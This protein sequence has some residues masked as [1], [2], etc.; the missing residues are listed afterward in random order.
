MSTPHDSVRLCFIGMSNCGKSTR[1]NQLAQNHQFEV[2]HVDER[3]EAALKPEL[4]S[5]GFSGIE[6]MSSWMGQ[7]FD[8]RFAGN[9]KRYLELEEQITLSADFEG[10]A[11]AVLDCTG[12]V[13]NINAPEKLRDR[14][15]VVHFEATEEIV[16]AMVE[17]YFQC[18]KPVAWGHTFSQRVGESGEEALRRCYPEMLKIRL[19]KYRSLAHFSIPATVSLDPNFSSERFLDLILANRDARK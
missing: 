1:A 19:E 5:L 4:E 15:L 6:G 9:Q 7:P 8:E 16:D 17:R 14:F 11:A 3:I 2:L 10:S 18:P 12:S 13:I